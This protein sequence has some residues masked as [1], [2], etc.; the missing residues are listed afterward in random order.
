MA[1]N[2]GFAK[3]LGF[4][5]QIAMGWLL[6]QEDFAVYAIAISISTLTSVL[7]DSGL[8]NL[9]IQRQSEYESLVGPVFWMSLSLNALAATMLT[10]LALHAPK[11]FHGPALQPILLLIAAATLLATPASVLSVKLRIQLDFKR[12][13]FIQICSSVIRYAGMVVCAYVGLGA[14]SFVLPSVVINL[15]EWAATWS[16]TRSAPWRK[17]FEFQ[18]WHTIFGQVKWLLL[19][20]FSIGLLNNGLYFALSSFVDTAVI[21]VYFFAYQIV[22]QVG[23][24]LSHNLFQVLFPA[25]SLLVHAPERNRSAITRAL[26]LVMLLAAPLSLALVPSFDLLEHLLWHGKWHETVQ[27]VQIL[28]FFYPLSVLLSIPLAA[29]SA[30]GRFRQTGIMT[31][32]LALGTITAGLIGAAMTGTATGIA[33]AT[34]IFTF[35]GSII[36]LVITLKIENMSIGPILGSLLHIWLIAVLAA[37]GSHGLDLFFFNAQSVGFRILVILAV[38]IFSFGILVRVMMPHRLREIMEV[39]PTRVRTGLL[40]FMRFA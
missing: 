20:T 13:S 37:A 3:L 25:F 32:L 40:G 5:A 4:A 7:A 16:L 34:G 39:L 36:Y 29:Q 15:F 19:G 11:A 18:L 1:L 17:P 24:L 30:Q 6:S 22:I 12:L 31:L 8:R 2:A 35:L 38:F 10:T 14:I 21:G 23:I 26:Y 28:S 27:P 33:L 9:L